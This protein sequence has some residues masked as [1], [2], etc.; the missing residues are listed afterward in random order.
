MFW[1]K[2]V[3]GRRQTKATKVCNSAVLMDKETSIK[4]ECC[5]MP[6]AASAYLSKLAIEEYIWKIKLVLEKSFSEQKS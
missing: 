1:R 5:V 3:Q 2:V 6:N 4:T